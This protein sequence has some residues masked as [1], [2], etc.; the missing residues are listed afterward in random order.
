MFTDLSFRLR[1]ILHRG[2]VE[3]ELREE[4]EAHLEY[5]KEKYLRAGMAVEDAGRAAAI[6][7]GG[8]EQI[9]QQCRDARGTQ[10]LENFVLDVRYGTRLHSALLHALPCLV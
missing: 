8:A 10:R 7:L 2:R 6:A 5:E 3:A 9:R 1:A 4:I